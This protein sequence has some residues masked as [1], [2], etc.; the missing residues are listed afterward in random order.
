MVDDPAF[1]ERRRQ[2]LRNSQ[3]PVYDDSMLSGRQIDVYEDPFEGDPQLRK[4]AYSA[5]GAFLRADLQATKSRGETFVERRPTSDTQD[6][7]RVSLR[8]SRPRPVTITP[9]SAKY[10]RDYSQQ[11][12]SDPDEYDDDDQ[13]DYEMDDVEDF[14]EEEEDE[15]DTGY[16]EQQRRPAPPTRNLPRRST[17]PQ[18]NQPQRRRQD[19]YSEDYDRRPDVRQRRADRYPQGQ[20]RGRLPNYNQAAPSVPRREHRDQVSR[21]ASPRT[22]RRL[23]AAPTEPALLAP[24]GTI[25]RNPCGDFLVI[26]LGGRRIRVECQEERRE[27][28]DPHHPNMPHIARINDPRANGT[29][30]F[31]WN[32]DNQIPE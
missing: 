2:R 4:E 25:A 17:V 5:M 1:A 32:H 21:S 23:V 15:W 7:S 19:R 14:E 10:A 11:L 16:L 31:V 13:L 26:H 20:S 28:Q 24:D 12:Q 30:Y 22:E 3:A 27:I 29:A 8:N 18:S 6:N 9:T